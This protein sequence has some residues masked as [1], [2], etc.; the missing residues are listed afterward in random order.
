MDDVR[1]GDG[2]IYGAELLKDLLKLLPD[3][4]EVRVCAAFTGTHNRRADGATMGPAQPPLCSQQIK[5]LRAFKGDPDK[6]TLVDSFMYLL[7]QVPRCVSM[8]TVCRV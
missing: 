8:N 1:R 3:S 2:K 4:E 7:I 5:K 6:L